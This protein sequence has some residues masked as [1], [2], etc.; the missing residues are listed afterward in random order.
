[1]SYWISCIP[2]VKSEQARDINEFTD[3]WVFC[4]SCHQN[5]QD[6]LRID[7]ANKFVSFVRRQYPDDTQKLMWRLFM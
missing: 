7:I 4:P 5:Y 6:E 3:P 2:K 1:V